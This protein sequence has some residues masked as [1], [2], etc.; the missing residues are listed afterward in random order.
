LALAELITSHAYDRHIRACR[1]RYRRRRD[2]L[3]A[4]LGP[5][6]NVRGIAAGLHALVDVADEDAVLARAFEEGLAVGCLGEHW[7]GAREGRPQGLVVGYGTPRERVYPEA[8]EVLGR[9]LED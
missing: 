8:L 5:R 3:L 4:R 1:L 6:R 2:Q 9:V 7:H